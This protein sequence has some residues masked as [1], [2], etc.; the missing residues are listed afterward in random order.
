MFAKGSFICYFCN[1]YICS[2][3][4]AILLCSF[5]VYNDCPTAVSNLQSQYD[6]LIHLPVETLL[7][8][9]YASRVVDFNQ[10]QEVG[11]MHTRAEKMGYILDLIIDSLKAGTAIKYSKFLEVMKNSEDSVPNEIVKSLG[12]LKH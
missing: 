12:K 7:P 10:K 11:A 2:Y 4:H 1:N 9:L 3:S 8:S 5:I 6:K